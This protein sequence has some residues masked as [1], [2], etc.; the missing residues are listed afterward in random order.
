MC[1]T[2]SK[3]YS[4][5]HHYVYTV[6][7]P[8]QKYVTIIKKIFVP[9]DINYVTLAQQLLLKLYNPTYDQHGD[10]PVESLFSKDTVPCRSQY[11]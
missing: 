8:R 6:A 9:R 5:L 7:L 3:D 1:L 4:N 2:I 10:E 11:V